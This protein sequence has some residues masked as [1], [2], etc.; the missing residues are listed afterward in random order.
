[1]LSATHIPQDFI[2]ATNP[3]TS[4]CLCSQITFPI[5]DMAVLPVEFL[6]MTANPAGRD[7]VRVAW[8][9][10]QR[11]G[12]AHYRIERGTNLGALLPVGTVG[13][14]GTM[15]QPTEY[16]FTD[17]DVPAGQWYYRVVGVD[18]DGAETPSQLASVRLVA[19]SRIVVGPNPT[20]R[21]VFV[22]GELPPSNAITVWVSDLTGRTLP[23][24]AE[25][26]QANVL[27]VDLLGLAA[28]TYVL[29]IQNGTSIQHFNVLVVE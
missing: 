14:N 29:H 23:V 10:V 26:Q 12:I 16:A 1:V 27:R 17:T 6:S 18:A 19:E 7:A 8:Q 20:Q 25:T 15:H 22:Q 5:S 3:A 13:A 2:I 11:P 24:A 21:Y 4:P 9:V 28:G